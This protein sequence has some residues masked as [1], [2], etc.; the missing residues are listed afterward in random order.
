MTS[1]DESA[2]APLSITAVGGKFFR[3]VFISHFMCGQQSRL[4]ANN[5]ESQH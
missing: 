3:R 2:G 5:N 1:L 4:K